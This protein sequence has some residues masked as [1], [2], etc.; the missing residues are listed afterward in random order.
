MK[1]MLQGTLRQTLGNPWTAAPTVL[2]S[3][4]LLDPEESRSSDVFW[5]NV[6]RGEQLQGEAVTVLAPQLLQ[7]RP[8]H[9]HVACSRSLPPSP[10]SQLADLGPPLIAFGS[11]PAAQ[12]RG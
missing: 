8:L 5:Q 3:M 10:Q 11:T 2:H 6:S 9:V 1:R 7:Q 12:W 4:F